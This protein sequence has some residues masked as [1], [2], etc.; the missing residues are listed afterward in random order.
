MITVI[1]LI[2][3]TILMNAAAQLLLKAGMNRIGEFA[4]S[5]SNITPIMLK[6][7]FSPLIIFGL[8]IYVFS[9][10]IW[11][12]VLSR[13]DASIAYPMT[14]LGYIVTAIAAYFILHEQLSA[15]QMVGIGVIIIGVYLVAHH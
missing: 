5:W 4:L 12:F 13:V 14:S 10:T 6:V 2:L 8:F 7:A 11:L 9:V 3:L 1:P 15:T